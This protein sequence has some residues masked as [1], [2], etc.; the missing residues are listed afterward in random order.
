MQASAPILP[1]LPP[2]WLLAL[3]LLLVSLP[4]LL[5]LVFLPV[6]VNMLATTPEPNE[7]HSSFLPARCS[8]CCA[9][10]EARPL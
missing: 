5:L 2:T 9:N 3:L 7:K 8:P 1:L 6:R 4:L 10:S